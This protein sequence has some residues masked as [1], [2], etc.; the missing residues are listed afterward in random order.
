MDLSSLH[1]ARWGDAG[2]RVIMVHGGAQGGAVGGEENFA[3]QRDV[4]DAGFRL[5][6]PDR[7]GHGRS[8]AQ[9]WPDDAAKDGAWVADLLGGASEGGAHLVGHS[10]GG[11][12]ALDAAARRP[13][14][15]RSL[16]MIEPA[17]LAVAIGDK[18]VRAFVLGIVW[19]TISSLSNKSRANRMFAYL[20]IP[21]HLAGRYDDAERDR[22]GAAFK[23]IRIPKKPD[24]ERQLAAVRAAGIPVLVVTGGWSKAFDIASDRAATLAGGV[25]EVI[26]SPHHFPQTIGDT[27]SRR[28]ID[29]MH[30]A[31]ARRD[32]QG[33]VT[34]AAS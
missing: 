7:P 11:A 19:R 32:V 5:I 23:R 9:D 1:I 12:V 10:F 26:A 3:N 20:G 14:L 17:V 15:V 16:T 33:A 21:P 6:V 4:A 18:T 2:P 30:A 31:D 22:L 24:L 25:H 29:F 34:A 8:P 27:F 13:E 28:L